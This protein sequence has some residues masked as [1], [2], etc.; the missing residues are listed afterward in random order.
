M[1]LLRWTAVASLAVLVAASGASAQDGLR[2]LRAQNAAAQQ[3]EMARQDL[4]ATQREIA[5]RQDQAQTAFVLRELDGARTTPPGLRPST[6][7]VVPLAPP[8]PIADSFTAQMDRM[9]RLTQ[10]AL[11]RSN[12]QVRAVRPAS[13]R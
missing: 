7:A 13:E 11:A 12:A 4:L 8:P 5:A 2:E 1:T 9:E 3:A 10:D 6:T